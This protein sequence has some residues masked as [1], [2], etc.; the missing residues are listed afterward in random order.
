MKKAF[1]TGINGFIGSNLAK[2]LIDQGVEVY[3][4]VRKSSDLSF[5]K[6]LNLKLFRGDI[7][8]PGTLIPEW[9]ND[10]DTVFHVAG[11]AADW[12]PYGLFYKINVEG[13]RNLAQVCARF[14]C[15]IV[16][17]SSDYV[18]DGK[19][20]IPQP[21][22]EDD[23]P[24]PLSFYGKT[25]ADSEKAVIDNIEDYIIIRTGW[26]YGRRGSN[27][28]KWVIKKAISGE[29]IPVLKDQYG[30]PT[31]TYKVALQILVL[32]EKKMTGIFHA[33]SEGYCTRVEWAKFILDHLGLSAE[34]EPI[35]IK[36]WSPPAK[37]PVNCLLEN[38]ELK[39]Y[40]LSIMKNWKD[41]LKDFL[42]RFGTSLIKE[43]RQD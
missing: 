27:F 35:S 14:D 6:G 33:T 19:K 11:L 34:L 13:A 4:L 12:G 23:E 30:S 42:N 9:F 36:D 3:G 43:V 40:R 26:L 18:F 1:I 16:H 32:L 29:K 2:Q 41:E 28:V 25:K 24:N 37:R 21:Y 38:K 17:I 10:I 22:F 39:T 8:N 7:T 31:W 15:K 5:I 20:S